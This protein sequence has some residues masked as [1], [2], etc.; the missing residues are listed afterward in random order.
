VLDIITGVCVRALAGHQAPVGRVAFSEDGTRIAS[1]DSYKEVRIW[2][3]ESGDCVNIFRIE[4][5]VYNLEFCPGS[6]SRLLTEH[7]QIS[8]DSHVDAAGSDGDLPL[9][10]YHGFH[11]SDGWIW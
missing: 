4:A 8:F 3:A 1:I 11:M 6:S 7:G 10:T 5:F 9:A 2:D